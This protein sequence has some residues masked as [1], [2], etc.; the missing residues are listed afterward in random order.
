[1]FLTKTHF[2][3]SIR[4]MKAYK[5]VENEEELKLAVATDYAKELFENFEIMSEEEKEDAIS[6]IIEEMSISIYSVH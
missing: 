4:I 2:E 6:M 1:M 3:E 5:D